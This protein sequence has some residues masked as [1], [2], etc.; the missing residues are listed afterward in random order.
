[1]SLGIVRDS[2]GNVL[3]LVRTDGPTGLHVIDLEGNVLALASTLPGRTRPGLDILVTGTR[4][5][6][7]IH[8]VLA[9]TLAVELLRLDDLRTVA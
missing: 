3:L 4:A 2:F 6:Q 8:L 1:G 7:R 5:R 9:L